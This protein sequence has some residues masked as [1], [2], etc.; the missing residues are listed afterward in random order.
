R[1]TD[2]D[3]KR[4]KQRF[5][6]RDEANKELRRIQLEIGDVRTGVK[7]APPPDRTFDELADYWIASVA[8]RKRSRKHDE[9]ILRAH[10]RP[11]FGPMRLREIG[12]ASVDRYRATRAHLDQKTVHNHLTLL[13]SMLNVAVELG[14]LVK[15]PKIKKPK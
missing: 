12:R 11:I 14:W 8:P 7:V 10:L 2:L 9:S 1:W 3:G 4:R 13:I 6:R 5:A 15:A